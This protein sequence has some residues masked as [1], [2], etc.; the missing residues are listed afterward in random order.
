MS[1]QTGSRDHVALDMEMM[2]VSGEDTRL[3]DHKASSPRSH[4]MQDPDADGAEDLPKPLA[5]V[6]AA[7]DK[8]IGFGVGLAAKL[9]VKAVRAKRKR[10]VFTRTLR[11][12]ELSH[13]ET[14]PDFLNLD[15]TPGVI[16]RPIDMAFPLRVRR[17]KRDIELFFCVTVH[18]QSGTEL[19][20]TLRGIGEWLPC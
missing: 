5:P 15:Y 7:K 18:K 13:E 3:E 9:K 17:Q 10:R 20:D 19:R 4:P 12:D 6:H 1:N 8:I 14:R 2:D 16:Q 11:P